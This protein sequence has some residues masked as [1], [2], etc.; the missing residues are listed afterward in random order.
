MMSRKTEKQV[1]SPLWKRAIVRFLLILCLLPFAVWGV[2]IF[3]F[4]SW[5]QAI[6]VPLSVLFALG[7]GAAILLLPIRR[8]LWA[9]A[10]L[11]AM[12]LM[13]FFLMKPSL[14]RVWQPDVNQLPYADISG[15]KVV[16]HNVRNCEYFSETNY[17]VRYETRTY[18]L[19]RLRS[20]DILFSDWGV[21]AI[22]HTMLSFGFE[23]G[24]YLCVSIETRKEVGEAYSA[25]KGFFR[26]YELIYIAADER[27]VVRLRTNYRVGEDVYLYR[28]QVVSLGQIRDTFLEYLN[29]MN[30]L[31][32]HAEWY[33]A[34]T[35]NCM[36][37]GF[38][39]MKKHAASGRADLHWSVVLNGYAA[40]HA[41]TTGT[42]NTSVPFDELK[43]RGG[44]NDR[45]RAADTAPDFSAKI[46][47]GIPGMDWRPKPG[48]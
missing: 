45:A 12:A 28:V 19:S 7:S 18:D 35:D 11:F 43:R 8:A 31:H 36:T 33:N 6:D 44:I 37:S 38:R 15:E 29:R 47:A 26:Q 40:D 4:G 9:F 41:Y 24:E 30:G 17:V 34:L 3:V 48:E 42:L 5:P 46:R 13:C 10:G 25:L 22:A 16:L 23:G 32:E 1:V 14:H 2:L 21:H 39:I 27:D 20:V